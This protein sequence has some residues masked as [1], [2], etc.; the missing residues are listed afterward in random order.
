M[1]EVTYY[2]WYSGGMGETIPGPAGYV[3]A[4]DYIALQQQVKELQ[5]QVA[6]LKKEREAL[7]QEITRQQAIRTQTHS[8]DRTMCQELAKVKEERDR[9]KEALTRMDASEPRLGDDYFLEI[10]TFCQAEARKAL[11]P[12]RV[13]QPQPDA[14]PGEKT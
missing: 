2:L 8:L 1:S 6:E 5:G 13:E 11:Y 3:Q 9:Y 7:E 4:N 14:G 10:A 12:E